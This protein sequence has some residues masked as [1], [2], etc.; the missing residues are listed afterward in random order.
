MILC[1]IG[2]TSVDLFCEGERTKLSVENFDPATLHDDVYYVSVNTL[3]NEQIQK[4]ANWHDVRELID[5]DKYYP[6]MGIDRIMVCEAVEE[7]VIV[8]AGSAI[9]VDMMRGGV[10]QGGFISLGLR[11]AYEAYARVSPA[12]DMSFNFEVDLVKM[13]KNTP[14]ALTVGFLAPLILKIESLGK[15]IYMSGGDARL[16]SRFL[17]E[18]TVDEE[19]IFKGMKKLIEKGVKC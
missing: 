7:G 16:L 13:A 12:L 8:D 19:L 2:N 3:F 11:A 1:D 18:A 4:Y 9:T 15:P 5:W 17:P 14:D 6:T 10:Y